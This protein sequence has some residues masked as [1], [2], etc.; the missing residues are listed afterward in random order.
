MTAGRIVEVVPYR[1]AH[2]A[3]AAR[4]FRGAFGR[5]RRRV[6]ALPDELAEPPAARALLA[7][8]LREDRALVA[9]AGSAVVG[10]LGWWELEAFRDT[11][12]RAAYSPEFGQAAAR[13]G[14]V[15]VALA[16]YHAATARWASAGCEVHAFTLLA[17]Q[18]ALERALFRNGFGMFVEDALRPMTAVQALAP[19]GITVRRAV[20]ADAERVAALDAEHQ[21]HYA[22]PPLSMVPRTPFAAADVSAF[23]AAEPASIWLAEAAGEAQAFLQLEPASHGAVRISLAPT[24]ISIT[25]A[26]TR[27]AW[28]G[29]GLAAALLARAVDHYAAA[30]FLRMAVDYETF[31]PWAVAFWRRHFEPVAVSVVRVV[32]HA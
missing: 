4:L 3:G 13:P 17:G 14:G 27:P 30:G 28:R 7:G 12:R 32:E 22:A 10:Y 6:P 23:L 19:E 9:M 16:L 18:P 15:E 5:L 29:R 8:F 1:A 31:N 11:P 25:G 26:F 2:L 21:R 24:T 20:P